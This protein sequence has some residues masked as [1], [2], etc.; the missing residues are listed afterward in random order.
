MNLSSLE[1][2]NFLQECA[3]G[4]KKKVSVDNLKLLL[5]TNLPT[6]PW[7]DPKLLLKLALLPL[8]V[9]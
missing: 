7:L 2:T 3:L 5:Q 1:I 8:K 6:L 4:I 9:V